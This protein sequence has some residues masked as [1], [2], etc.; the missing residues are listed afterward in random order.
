M[1]TEAIHYYKTKESAVSDEVMFQSI[2][3]KTISIFDTSTWQK[4]QFTNAHEL[5]KTVHDCS[6]M[7][8]GVELT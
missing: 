6:Y 4:I 8:M 2:I 3:W 5:P 1:S 7:K